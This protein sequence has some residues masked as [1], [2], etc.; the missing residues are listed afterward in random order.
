MSSRR[1]GGN[2]QI[3]QS[4]PPPQQIAWLAPWMWNRRYQ[5]ACG[6]VLAFV[7]Y[8]L[9]A[10]PVMVLVMNEWVPPGIAH[11]IYGPL[12]KAANRNPALRDW[13]MWY[14]DLFIPFYDPP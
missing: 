2:E 11:I 12:F 1:V 10:G 5:I 6:L 9:S 3:D 8:V 7:S 13:L 14:I 4:S